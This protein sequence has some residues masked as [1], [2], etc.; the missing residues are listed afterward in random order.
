MGWA[1]NPLHILQLRQGLELLLAGLA[2]GQDKLEVEALQ[3][4][5]GLLGE[6]GVDNAAPAAALQVIA[7]SHQLGDVLL[8]LA[9]QHDGAGRGSVEVSVK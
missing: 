2:E 5:A 6:A 4:Q 8:L 9:G 7:L 1:A 3:G